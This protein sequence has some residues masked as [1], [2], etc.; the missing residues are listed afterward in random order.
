M[1]G[2]LYEHI[3]PDVP[4]YLVSGHIQIGDVTEIVGDAGLGKDTLGAGLIGCLTTGRV[5]PGNSEAGPPGSAIMVTPEDSA[6]LTTRPRL[7]AA[8]AD[9]GKVLDLSFVQRGT[10][11]GTASDMFSIAD[12]VGVLRDAIESLPDCQLVWLSPLNAIAGCSIRTDNTVRRRVMGPLQTLARETGVAIVLVHHFVKSGAVG[13]SQAIVDAPRTVLVLE[14]DPNNPAIRVLRIHKTNVSAGDVRPLRFVIE[15]TAPW[16]FARFLDEPERVAGGVEEPLEPGKRPRPGSGCDR[17]L[18]ALE[19]SEEPR[20]SQSLHA[21]TK[22]AHHTVKVYLGRLIDAGWVER[23]D[24]NQY[25]AKVTVT[26]PDQGGHAFATVTPA[27]V[28]RLN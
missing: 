9:I 8:Q 15:G 7:D 1:Q 12:D 22:I 18:R 14:R 5:L 10:T 2:T 19:G 6:N 11:G 20:T 16:S 23:T 21:E 17:I 4:D 24:V 27:G 25:I 26:A 28:A 13:G 3:D